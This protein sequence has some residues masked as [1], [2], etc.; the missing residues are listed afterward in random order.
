MVIRR[1]TAVSWGQFLDP[2]DQ[3]LGST[4]PIATLKVR[5]RQ[6]LEATRQARRHP[7]VLLQGEVGT[8]KNLLARALHQASRRAAGPFVH[9]QCNAIPETLAESLL[10]GHERGAF[11][12]ADRWRP[13][14]FRSAH[15]GTVLLDEIGTLS[16]VVQARLLQ[17]ID[18]GLVPVIGLPM[19]VPVDV[20]VICATN[21]D[22]EEAVRE[23]RFRA[24]LLS[25]L[26]VK[27]T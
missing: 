25:R 23:R 18:E 12:G 6:L 21:V 5:A 16:E 22:L 19:P 27:F 26:T 7:P 3:L 14:Y 17:V 13:G 2:L 4:L 24:D 20:W 10:F 8:G 1:L 9:V 11:T 15:G